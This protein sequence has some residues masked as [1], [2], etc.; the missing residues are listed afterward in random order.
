MA[1]SADKTYLFEVATD[2]P[3][4]DTIDPG[5]EIEV[6]VE[7]GLD[8]IDDIAAVP[9]PFTPEAEGHPLAAV[10]GPFAVRGA[11]PGDSVAVTLWS[12]SPL[13]LAATPSCAPSG[14]W[15]RSLESRPSSPVPFATARRGS[16]TASPSRSIPISAPS[17]PYRRRAISRPMPGSMVFFADPHAA[18]SDGV[19]SG[20][21][22]ECTA[23]VRARIELHK[24]SPVDRPIIDHGDTVQIVGVGGSAEAA[25]EDAARGAVD[26][27]A[28]STSLTRR[29]AYMLLGIVG[30]VRVGTSPRPM[31][32]G[33]VIIEKK[34]CA[35]LVGTATSCHGRP[36]PVR[37]RLLALTA[38]CSQPGN[39]RCISFF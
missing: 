5:A 22:V 23:R 33:R 3:P 38:S 11:E 13:A 1:K 31:M 8:D 36:D 14:C 21:G 19:I 30:D 25:T 17:R 4:V 35:R 39:Q 28:R 2:T 24:N 18:I 15:P 9:R 34:C 27:L 26:F 7:G 10:T 37:P 20:T 6:M 12:L 32:A 29:D 16:P